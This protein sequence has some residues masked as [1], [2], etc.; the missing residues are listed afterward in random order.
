[1]HCEDV[2]RGRTRIEY[3]YIFMEPVPYGIPYSKPKQFKDKNGIFFI[4]VHIVNYEME[5]NET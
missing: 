4:D 5:E 2:G 3:W 1:M